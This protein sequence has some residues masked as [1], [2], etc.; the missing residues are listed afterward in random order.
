M[1]NVV[2]AV[3]RVA[4]EARHFAAGR[5]EMYAHALGAAYAGRVVRGV[6]QV[7]GIWQVVWVGDETLQPASGQAVATVVFRM[8]VFA[9]FRGEVVHGEVCGMSDCE[10][11]VGLP[12]FGV[13]Y[14]PRSAL[15]AG[16][17]WK[18]DAWSWLADAEAGTELYIDMHNH[19]VA[20]VTGV[21][22]RPKGATDKKTMAITAALRDKAEDAQ[23][24]GDPAWWYEEE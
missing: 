3:E 4:V 24:L 19:V 13:L 6:G 21:T 1:F 5:H 10:L 17:T 14:V 23:G 11:L 8:V 15:P 16:T 9:P 18:G 7:I 2:T 22:Y 12:F 20:R